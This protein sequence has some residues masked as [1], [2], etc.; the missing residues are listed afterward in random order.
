MSIEVRQFNPIDEFHEFL[1]KDNVLKDIKGLTIHKVI[2]ET[3]MG[4]TEPSGNK[5]VLISQ[6]GSTIA[7]ATIGGTFTLFK[8]RIQIDT[9]IK[10]VKGKDDAKTLAE[11]IRDRIRVILLEKE[12]LGSGWISH[13]EVNDS[14]PSPPSST[15]AVHRFTYEVLSGMEKIEEG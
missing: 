10:A 12:W 14:W 3:V 11:E 1:S 2:E 4:S 15:E 7:E 13:N 5:R 8:Q 6:D 9:F